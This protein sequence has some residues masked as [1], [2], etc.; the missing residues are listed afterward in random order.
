MG[1][2]SRRSPWAA[3]SG[4]FAAILLVSTGITAVGPGSEAA[5]ASPTVLDIPVSSSTNDA[6]ESSSGSVS[7]NSSDLELVYDKSNQTVGIRFVGVGV[8]KGATVTA[9]WVQFQTDRATSGTTSLTIRGQAADAAPAFARTTR[10]ISSRTRTAASVPWTPQSWGVSGERG[11]AQRTPDVKAVVQEIVSRSG[12]TQGNALALI[13]TGTGMRAAESIDGARA[14]M[15]HLEYTMPEPS[16][17]APTVSAGSDVSVTLPNPAPLTGMASDDGLPGGALITNWSLVEGPGAV[18]FDDSSSVS[19]SAMFS[20]AGAHTLRL[21]ADDGALSRSDDVVVTVVEPDTTPP[22]APSGLSAAASGATRVDLSWNA[23]DDNVGVI[24]YTVLRDGIEVGAPTA[25]TFR[26]TLVVPETTYEYRVVAHDAAG[27]SSAPSEPASAT[28]PAAPEAVTFAAAGDHGANATTEASLAV[29][30]GSGSEFYLAL[31]DLSYEETPTEAAWCQFVTTQLPT[32]G[33]TFPFQLVAGNH[34]EQGDLSYITNYTPCLPDRM[35]STPGPTTGYPVEYRF[36]YPAASPL[37]RVI[38]IAPGLTI[39]NE[40]FSYA[41]GDLHYQWL[42]SSIDDARGMGIPWVI[43]AMHKVCY[44]SGNHGCSLSSA[45]L[46]LLVDRKVD[47]V[48]QGHEHHYERLKQLARNPATCPTM[49][50]ASYDADCVVDDGW[51]GVYPKGAG[52]VFIISGTNGRSTYAINPADPHYPYIA[53]SD[54][55]SHGILRYTLTPERLDASFLASTGT[56]TDSF[57]IVPSGSNQP[58]NVRVGS[59]LAVVRPNLAGLSGTVTDDGL[60]APPGATS[61][62]WSMASGPGTVTFADPTALST[63]ASFSAPGTY[64]LRL[65]AS[66]T[67]LSGWD[68][69]M[70]VVNDEAGPPTAVEVPVVQSSDDAEESSTGNISLSS[71]DLELV[72][73]SSTQKVGVR[74]GNLPIPQGATVTAAWVQF[75]TDETKSGATALTIRGQAADNAVTFQ[76]VTGNVSSRPTT[77]ASVNWTPVPWTVLRERGASQRTPDLSAVIQAIVSRPGWNL[78]NALA[79]IVTGTGLRTAGAVDN[80]TAPVL[81]VEYRVG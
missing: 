32:L 71:S 59:D 50:T 52:T 35:S 69:L 40:S 25:A 14:P 81:H 56:F 64:V 42:A 13:I 11:A 10:N 34:E 57:S 44:S 67:V 43:V 55:S 79:L 65:T 36:D 17:V 73:E 51:D 18:T 20:A 31:G 39:E 38:T 22:S 58:P 77:S 24:G 12:W 29:L 48:L 2:P 23:A 21:T 30:D 53:R 6:E 15:L 26:D 45:L 49:S 54:A 3:L 47:L 7:T 60:P 63:S 66:D 78:G 41:S 37:V 5:A 74:F 28:T 68:E 4:A 80:G 70:V 62:S 19:T 8:P 16:N 33:P 72:Q 9:A 1:K 27:F 75:E 76:N 46:N 61:A